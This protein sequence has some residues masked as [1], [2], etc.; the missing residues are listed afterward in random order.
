M[1]LPST[2]NNIIDDNTLV[3]LSREIAMNVFKI[4]D[5]LDRH[6]I[7]D[8]AWDFI[9]NHPRFTQLLHNAVV[10]WESALNTED[11]VKVK[12]ATM[13]ELWLSHASSLLHSKTEDTGKKTELAKLICKLANLGFS[14][15]QVQGGASER[16]SITINLGADQLKIEKDI[17][18]K[19]IEYE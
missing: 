7:D 13:I 18:P 19:T 1:S 14:G 6:N 11:R 3:A 5:I 16:L 9:K 8:N 2:T 12:S 15:A 4:E 10:E 17:S